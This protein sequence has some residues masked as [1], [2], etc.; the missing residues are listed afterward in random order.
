VYIGNEDGI[1]NTNGSLKIRLIR[2]NLQFESEASDTLTDAICDIQEEVEPDVDLWLMTCF[3]CKFAGHALNYLVGDRE[4]WCYRDAPE[5]F[6]DVL[7][8][9]KSAKMSSRFAGA[10]F[11]NAFHTCAAWEL[12]Q[13][14]SRE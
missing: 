3:H 13:P 11:V 1:P 10:F 2:D 12:R 6:E 14:P 5:A 9:G 7:K 8:R 4:F